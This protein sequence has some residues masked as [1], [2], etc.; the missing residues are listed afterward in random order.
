[1]KSDIRTVASKDK[2]VK[3]VLPTETVNGPIHVYNH[4]D[5]FIEV[6]PLD[7]IMVPHETLT[8]KPV[9]H[10]VIRKAEDGTLQVDWAY[11]WKIEK[12]I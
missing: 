8:T 2:P 9:K 12:R 5:E 6:E 3:I 7:Y 4:S 10:V 11:D 1:M